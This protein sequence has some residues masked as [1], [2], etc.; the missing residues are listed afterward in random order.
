L[1]LPLVFLLFNKTESAGLFMHVVFVLMTLIISVATG[2]QFSLGST[3]MKEKMSVRSASLY[4]SDLV[5][6][7]FGALLVSVFMIPILGIIYSTFIIAAL[8]LISASV[9]F[10]FR[11][12]YVY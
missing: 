6:S 7:A 2:M 10:V 12:N 11:K 9:T 4:S 1:V 8:N 3:I 5:G